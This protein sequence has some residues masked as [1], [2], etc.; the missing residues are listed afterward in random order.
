MKPLFEI[1]DEYR[2]LIADLESHAE[3]NAGDVTDFPLLDRLASLEGDLK[4][5]CLNI[6]ALVKEMS[7]DGK[8]ILE[9]GES[10]VARG[11][12]RMNRAES[13]KEYLAANVPANAVF[14]DARA[15][16][17]WAGNGGKWPVEVM[18]EVDPETLPPA[19]KIVDT[20]VDMEAVRSALESQIS[21]ANDPSKTGQSI[22]LAVGNK[23]I[24]RLNPRGKSLRIR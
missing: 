4:T 13:L 5:K 3:A 21:D 6:A 18:P 20:R 22:E 23:V 17:S 24:A 8:A 19:F 7:A 14:E 1:S 16:I 11:R 15:K 9:L 12:A 10:I 2:A